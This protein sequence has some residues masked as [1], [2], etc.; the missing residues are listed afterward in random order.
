M[1]DPAFEGGMTLNRNHSYWNSMTDRRR[2]WRAENQNISLEE[3]S[4]NGTY[5]VSGSRGETYTVDLEA[6]SCGCPDWQKR[7][8]DGGCKHVLKAK[9]DRGLIDPLPTARTDFGGGDYRWGGEYS[10]QWRSLSRR[11]KKRDGWEC[12]SCG[13]KGGPFGEAELHAHHILPTSKG[14]EDRP[15]NLITVCR[16]CHEQEHGHRIPSGG[17]V[18][19]GASEEDPA[20]G[21]GRVS[22]GSASRTSGAD[23]YSIDPHAGLRPGSGTLHSTDEVVGTT[24]EVA[25]SPPRTDDENVRADAS[26]AKGGEATTHRSGSRNSATGDETGRTPVTEPSFGLLAGFVAYVVLAFLFV[27]LLPP[28][29]ETADWKAGVSMGIVGLVFLGK[30]FGNAPSGVRDLVGLILFGGGALHTLL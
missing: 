21:N 10:S 2:Q 7:A 25:E 26:V 23:T 19:S 30:V 8:P 5:V 13:T 15:D 28:F 17:N 27:V 3:Y 9:L 1:D 22:A 6:P 12:Q 14:G 4:G 29:L 16:T 24:P 18:G 11:T 20:T